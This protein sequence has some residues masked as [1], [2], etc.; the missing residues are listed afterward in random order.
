MPT[1]TEPITWQAL[2]G[3]RDALLTIATANG[4]FHDVTEVSMEL[5]HP[6]RKDVFPN[7]FVIADEMPNGQVQASIEAYVL[8][9]TKDAQLLAHRMLA[10]IIKALPKGRAL[11]VPENGIAGIDQVSKRIRQPEDGS[12]FIVPQVSLILAVPEQQY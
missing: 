9:D 6:T 2:E 7:L 10:D 12:K 3:L 8:R 11:S 1:Q 4:Y 5:F